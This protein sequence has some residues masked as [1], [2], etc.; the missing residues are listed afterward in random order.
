MFQVV[1][2]CSLNKRFGIFNL[3]KERTVNGLNSSKLALFM[4]IILMVSAVTMPVLMGAVKAMTDETVQ[5]KMP[6]NSLIV[7]GFQETSEDIRT[8]KLLEII[9]T[10]RYQVVK[11]FSRIEDEG[12]SIPDA[13]RDKYLE[14]RSKE[15]YAVKLRDE[16]LYEQASW[17]AIEA[18]RK[19]KEAITIAEQAVITPQK[20]ETEII[21]ERTI[22][23]SET[24]AREKDNID[25]LE[26]LT[27]E[28]EKK[29]FNVANM[30]SKI[31]QA[32]IILN[33]GELLLQTGNV[34]Q[35]THEL[36]AAKNIIDGSMRD[37]NQV[38]KI[39]KAQKAEVYFQQ[40]E[41]M[42]QS[43]EQK[44]EES[45]EDL[46]PQEEAAAKEVIQDSKVQMEEIKK[47]LEAGNVEGAIE[48]FEDVEV[49]AQIPEDIDPTE[50]YQQ[51]ESVKTDMY[52][53]ETTTNESVIDEEQ[54]SPDTTATTTTATTT[55]ATT[56]TATTTTM[57]TSDI[58]TNT[59]TSD[60]TT[61]TDRT[62]DTTTTKTT[63]PSDTTT[64][65][66]ITSSTQ[67]STT[68][69][70]TTRTD[71]SQTTTSRTTQ[72]Q[73]Q[74]DP[75]TD[76]SVFN[77]EQIKFNENI[78]ENSIDAKIVDDKQIESI[79]PKRDLDSTRAENSNSVNEKSIENSFVDEGAIK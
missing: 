76:E 67:T 37:L 8:N 30:R 78:D 14:G 77:E 61:T 26:V 7:I 10:S 54:V 1:P 31:R 29:G 75:P 58:E 3:S 18:M 33:N 32:E 57:T 59:A 20:Q 62:T 64:T 36:D 74:N 60:G 73:T 44:I 79:K 72:T 56:T 63:T 65:S 49:L 21:T 13:S 70:S 6:I 24:V 19:Y 11:T 55:T 69:S 25:R 52:S 71:T 22:G 46:T 68:T 34:E 40:T 9:E 16:G 42:L 17:N 51:N 4:L 5:N 39:I 27:V 43:Y 35:A 41:K 66:T 38:T 2:E 48:G 50:F 45:H 15:E 47:D 12:G 28:A 23:L 53:E